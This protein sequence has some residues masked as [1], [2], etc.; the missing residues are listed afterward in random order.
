MSVTS[1]RLFLGPTQ[2]VVKFLGLSVIGVPI[3]NNIDIRPQ[4]G[5]VAAAIFGGL[6][7]VPTSI[8]V[9]TINSIHFIQFI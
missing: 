1:S 5:A 2:A 6:K 4:C 3:Y 7:K 9:G 8:G